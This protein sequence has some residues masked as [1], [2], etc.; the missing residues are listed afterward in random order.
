VW[1]SGGYSSLSPF[2][3]MDVWRL[4]LDAEVWRLVEPYPGTN[5]H[6]IRGTDSP[7]TWYEYSW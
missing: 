2:Y 5:I 4:D 7:S 6:V 3:L 1:I